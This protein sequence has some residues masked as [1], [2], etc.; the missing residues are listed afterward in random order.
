MTT[1]SFNLRVPIGSPNLKQKY[2]MAQTGT[3]S[4]SPSSK[5]WV[6]AGTLMLRKLL[7]R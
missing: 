1:R 7:T 6:V 4:T 5:P 3:M 2:I